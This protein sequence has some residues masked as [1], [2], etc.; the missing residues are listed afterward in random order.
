MGIKN[1]F[2]SI[3]EYAPQAI[4]EIQMKQYAN[5]KIA[6]DVYILIYRFMIS[7]RYNSTNGKTYNYLQNESGDITSHLSG[8]YYKTIQLR[9]MGMLPIYVFD[10]IPPDM[11]KHHE[12]KKRQARKEKAMANMKEAK[13]QS[14]VEKYAK[15]CVFLTKK[16]IDD[17]RTLLKLMGAPVIDAPGEAEAQCAELCKKGLVDAVLT[18][19]MDILTFGAPRMLKGAMGNMSPTATCYELDLE[20]VLEGFNMNMTQF[21]EYCIICGCDYT[22]TI[23]QISYKR[24]K[25]L[26]DKYKSIEKILDTLVPDKRPSENE[27]EY[28]EATELFINPNILEAKTIP[29]TALKW[30]LYDEKALKEFLVTEK[31]FDADRLDKSLERY[32][33]ATLVKRQMTLSSMMGINPKRKSKN[34]VRENKTLSTPNRS[35]SSSTF[36]ASAASSSSDP[37]TKK[38]KPKKSV[39]KRCK[40]KSDRMSA[41]DEKDEKT[42]TS[43]GHPSGVFAPYNVNNAS[44]TI[45]ALPPILFTLTAKR[46]LDQDGDDDGKDDDKRRKKIKI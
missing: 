39:A 28:K 15:Q 6:I 2:K 9:E 16:E 45:I 13:T 40:N 41:T 44:S 25:P 32:K 38:L 4:T 37:K 10:G 19:D 43:L 42:S 46:K 1:L 36:S 23:P 14:E 8:L 5:R 24:G 29:P 34:D 18:E 12:L 30:G 26:M 11:K 35:V 22:G 7:V 31:G 20:K 17:A 33:K 21:I 27:F 3:G